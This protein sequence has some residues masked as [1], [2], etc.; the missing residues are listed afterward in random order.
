MEKIYVMKCSSCE[1]LLPLESFD[2]KYINSKLN[3]E[4]IEIKKK[5][6]RDC[7]ISVSECHSR[8]IDRHGVNYYQYRLKYKNN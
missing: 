5:T 1:H 2:T 4:K 7:L 3:D 8:F 6:C